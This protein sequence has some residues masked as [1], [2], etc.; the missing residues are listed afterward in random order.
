MKIRENIQPNNEKYRIY[1]MK[2]AALIKIATFFVMVCVGAV[3]SMLLPLRPS[4]SIY[5]KR[6][7]TQFPDFSF[8][9]FMNGTYFKNIDLWYADTFPFR[10][11]LILCSEG[12]DNLYGIRTSMVHGG[13]VAGDEIPDVNIDTDEFFSFTGTSD[14]QYSKGDSVLEEGTI[15][16]GETAEPETDFSSINIS[17]DDIGTEVED[18]DGSKAAQAGETLGTIFIAGGNAYN[19]YA[20]SQ[21]TSD[22]YINLVNDMADQLEGKAAVYDMIVPTSIDITLDDAT[23]NSI[24]SSNQ[25]K[26]ILYMYSRLS[27]KVGKTYVYDV[28]KEHRNE[29]IYFDT[30]H[31]WTADGAYYAYTTFMKQLGKSPASLDRFQRIEFSGFKGSFYTQSGISALADNPD[32]V[33]AYKPLSTNHIKFYNRTYDLTDYNII[34][35]VSGWNATSKYSTFIGGDNPFSMINNPDI[36]DGSSILVIKESYGNAFVPFLTESYENVYVIDYRYYT[37][38]VSRIVDEYGVDTVLFLN[39]IGATSTDARVAEMKNVCK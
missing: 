3:V 11:Q 35:D 34:T 4:E 20:F 1:I 26:A 37:G 19:Y 23:R 8:T 2:K 16:A 7:L 24:T 29:Y 32:M 10:D 25:Q 21:R 36:H 12:V 18:T 22:E 38:T 9:E 6:E 17:A 33:V 30:D 28:L 13:V 5:E 27:S 39:N 14:K 15:I 31:H